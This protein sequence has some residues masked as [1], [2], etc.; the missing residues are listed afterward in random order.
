MLD[1]AHQ[2]WQYHLVGNFDAESVEINLQEIL[3]FTCM[4]KINFISNFFS[5]IL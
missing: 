4:Q 5:E 1:C 3:M 2:K